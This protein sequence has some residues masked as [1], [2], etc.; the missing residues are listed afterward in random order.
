MCIYDGM[1]TPCQNRVDTCG[2][3]HKRC[4]KLAPLAR[5][6]NN[7]VMVIASLWLYCGRQFKDVFW[8]FIEVISE[9]D[10]KKSDNVLPF[11]LRLFQTLLFQNIS[12]SFCFLT[13]QHHVVDIFLSITTISAFL[14]FFMVLPMYH[15][16]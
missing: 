10:V 9:K 5:Q 2:P 3:F 16:A 13:L 12:Q 14:K 1:Q 11:S 4:G 8:H 15:L 6:H 7:T